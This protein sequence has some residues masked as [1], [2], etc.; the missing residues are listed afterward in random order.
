M[1]IALKD[2]AIQPILISK[3]LAPGVVDLRT[4]DFRQTGVLQVEAVASLVS[5]EIRIQ[6]NLEVRIEMECSRCL[7]PMQLP[8][9]KSFDLFYCSSKKLIPTSKD[10]EIELKPEELDVGFFVGAGLE[11][12]D[13][14]REQILIEIPMKPVCS[15]EC[16]GLCPECGANLN[17]ETCNCE[18]ER[19]DPR[20]EQLKGSKGS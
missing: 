13:T 6:G 15:P 5:E 10:E 12:N 17:T 19:V 3:A 18:K 8:V 11:I 14:L 2:L 4:P 7:E 20:W 9:N 1:F 16:R